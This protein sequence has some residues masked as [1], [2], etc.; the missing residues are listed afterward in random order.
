MPQKPCHEHKH[1]QGL[2]LSY[3]AVSSKLLGPSR[4]PS[5]FDRKTKKL[6][7]FLRFEQVV[8]AFCCL[9]VVFMV[10]WIQSLLFMD[11]A[12][13]VKYFASSICS[14]I[15]S[16]LIEAHETETKDT[17]YK[18]SIVLVGEVIRRACSY[19]VKG[20]SGFHCRASDV[21]I[22][23]ETMSRDKR[24][25]LIEFQDGVVYCELPRY[26]R[27]NIDHF[28]EIHYTNSGRS[29]E[30]YCANIGK[31]TADKTVKRAF[32]K[33][34]GRTEGAYEKEKERQ[35]SVAASRKQKQEHYV[36]YIQ[37]DNDPGFVKIGYSL[38]PAGRIAGFLTGSPRNLQILR[39][40]PV[41]SSQDELTRHLKFDEYRHTREWFRYEGA[42]REYI[43]SLS[44]NPAIELWQQFPVTSKEAIKVEYF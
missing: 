32:G 19:R 26:V 9:I 15:Y 18:S 16:I 5:V 24:I 38:S 28:K 11:H 25:K 7:N 36:Y 21:R 17:R 31:S 27:R 29:S 20:S 44:V 40:E 42:L 37:W 22:A 3:I 35:N 10:K 33:M 43:Q 4:K 1:E 23:I 13:V 2:Y 39:L 41:V 30:I 8:I 14:V 34:R 12:P 6:Q